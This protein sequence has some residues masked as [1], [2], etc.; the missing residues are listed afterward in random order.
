[1]DIINGALD[2]AGFYTKPSLI[3]C[4]C[5]DLEVDWDKVPKKADDNIL[6]YHL[7]QS[8][9]CK[10]ALEWKQIR[11]EREE[12]RKQKA[13]NTRQKAFWEISL[14]QA[15]FHRQNP[16]ECRRCPEIFSSNTQLHAH[17]QAHHM[18]KRSPPP[19]PRIPTIS[20][21]KH[22]ENTENLSPA[23]PTTPPPPP[24]PI[25]KLPPTPPKTPMKPMPSP[26][27]SPAISATFSSPSPPPPY[28]PPH[29]RAR[30]HMTIEDLFK[31]FGSIWSRGTC[32]VSI[33]PIKKLDPNA[34]EWL[35]SNATKTNQSEARNSASAFA[36]PP[37]FAATQPPPK[38]CKH[39]NTSTYQI[40]NCVTAAIA[41]LSEHGFIHWPAP[42]APAVAEKRFGSLRGNWHGREKAKR[43]WTNLHVA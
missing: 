1:M 43:C 25:E 17:I 36:Y 6:E 31:K 4:H 42:G 39:C 38:A 28:L 15:A 27:A 34:P 7:S 12:K 22:V 2:S 41:Y 19:S 29:K 20:P 24:K 21:P 14:L 37:R 5:C 8:P 11:L 13:T 10:Y 16:Y 35:P 26:Q 33:Q 32:S 40:A 18:K 9:S 30:S 23:P 3:K